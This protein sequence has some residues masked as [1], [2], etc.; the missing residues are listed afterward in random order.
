VSAKDETSWSAAGRDQ[1]E[2]AERA[3]LE[4][5]RAEVSELLGRRPEPRRRLDWRA[6][7]AT[8]LILL[9]CVLA[10]LS[11]LGVWTA[12]QVSD[13]SRYVANMAPLASDP[14]IQRALTDKIT[15]EVSSQLNVV[16]IT[17]LAASQ[18]ASK[19]LTRA[20]TALKSF[21]PQIASA[22]SGFIRSQVHNVVTSPAFARL[23]VRLNT[24]VHAQ[25]VKALSGHG[26]KAISIQNGYVTLSLG[27]VIDAA[28][29]QLDIPRL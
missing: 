2:P 26:S 22:V 6:P 25:L 4:R 9:G 27:P 17:D 13:T 21:A 1:L 10:P 29:Q 5:L 8:L 11:V 23:W 20:R 24:A 7:I 28:E 15:N 3:E 14:A 16:G 19:G 12:N 18:L